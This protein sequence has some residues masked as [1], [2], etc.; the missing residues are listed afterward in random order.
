MKERVKER[1]NP[2]YKALILAPIRM[3]KCSCSLPLWQHNI[4][5]KKYSKKHMSYHSIWT[6]TPPSLYPNYKGA[7]SDMRL[8]TV[9]SCVTEDDD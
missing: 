7:L 2:L 3:F 1:V 4:K 8:S 5:I 6:V 9:E